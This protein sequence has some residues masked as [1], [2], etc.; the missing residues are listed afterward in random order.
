MSPPRASCAQAARLSGMPHEKI[1]PFY[2]VPQFMIHD[3]SPNKPQSRW[4]SFALLALGLALLPFLVDAG[5][6]RS[7]LQA[8]LQEVHSLGCKR[9]H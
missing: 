5:L 6:G 9:P 8:V 2:F 3:T 4:L 7:R 1:H